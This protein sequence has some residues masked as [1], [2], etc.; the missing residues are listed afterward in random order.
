MKLAQTLH[1]SGDVAAAIKSYE[2]S[3][4]LEPGN[5]D[6]RYRLGILKAQSGDLQSAL[7][8]FGNAHLLARGGVEFLNHY[9][10]AAGLLDQ[11]RLAVSIFEE[12]AQ[13]NDSDV[14]TSLDFALAL[15][16]SGELGRSLQTLRRAIALDPSQLMLI[17]EM[18]SL[19]CESSPNGS[20]RSS[21]TQGFCIY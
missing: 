2:F 8:H 12:I 17:V 10:L 21:K 6:A 7:L 5:F 13:F 20:R 16:R 19:Q 15:K 1:Q 11:T 4:L 14:Q 18:A 9:A 3:T